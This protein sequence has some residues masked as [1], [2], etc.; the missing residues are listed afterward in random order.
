MGVALW[1]TRACGRIARCLVACSSSV[2]YCGACAARSRVLLL[3]WKY[4]CCAG[5]RADLQH[6]TSPDFGA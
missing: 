3:H 5:P 1:R 2:V 4:G 6:F